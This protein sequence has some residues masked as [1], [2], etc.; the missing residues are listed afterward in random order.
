LRPL[1]KFDENASTAQLVREHLLMVSPSGLVSMAG[2]KWTS[3][4]RMAEEAVDRAIASAGL[5]ASSPCKTLNLRLFGAENFVPE[6]FLVLTKDY[7]IAADIAHHLQHAFGDQAPCVARLAESGLG[8]RLHPDHP[9]IEA[10]VVYAARH[11]LAEHASDVLTRR[12]PLA[13]LDNAAAQ[14]TVARVVDLMAGE[15]G[16]DGNRCQQETEMALER[17]RISI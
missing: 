15:Q 14:A 13:I 16:W 5:Q 1:V 12:I 6:I 17:L 8:T 3:Y 10:E 4:R 2:G 7:G 11:E 9:Y